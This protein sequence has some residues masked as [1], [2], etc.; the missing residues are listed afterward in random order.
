MK[1][2][3]RYKGLA[4]FEIYKRELK[5]KRLE[6]SIQ[7]LEISYGLYRD[8]EILYTYG[9]LLA[10]QSILLKNITDLDG[11]V[12]SW[13]GIL[14]LYGH[15]NWQVNKDLIEKI[16]DYIKVS[17]KFVVKIP[18]K[19]YEGRFARFMIVMACE[20][21]ENAQLNYDDQN[22]FNSYKNK[23]NTTKINR[24]LDKLTE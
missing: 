5:P 17:E 21:A 7:S 2:V 22:F 8:A 11:L 14:E 18:S 19:R 23:Y 16:K 13:I 1:N 10:V 12:K 20:L 15:N 9:Y 3:Y 6:N 4:E 24:L